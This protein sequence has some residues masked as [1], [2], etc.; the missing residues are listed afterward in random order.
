MPSAPSTVR[1]AGDKDVPR[2]GTW[3]FL[4]YGSTG[5]AAKTTSSAPPSMSSSLAPIIAPSMESTSSTST[6]TT[7]S[8]T[9]TRR[10]RPHLCNPQ[11]V[12]DL[13]FL[14]FEA[15]LPILSMLSTPLN[16][17]NTITPSSAFF[18]SS[19]PHQTPTSHSCH[20]PPLLHPKLESQPRHQSQL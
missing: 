14:F 10:E 4:W 12:L 16:T 2:T 3:L 6:T 5:P 11:I 8:T 9:D 20:P 1:V 17:W 13:L 18:C 7:T 19:N 15:V